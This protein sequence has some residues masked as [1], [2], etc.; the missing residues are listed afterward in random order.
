MTKKTK[1]GIYILIIVIVLLKEEVYQILFQA[2][3]KNQTFTSIC[4][5]KNDTLEEKYQELINAYG[6]ED[7][8]PYH[9]EPSKILYRDIYNLNNQ[10]TIYKGEK[11]GIVSKN[12]VINE[13]GLVGIVKETSK[14][15]SVVDLL[16]NENTNLSI[17]IGESYG[18]LKY[19]D[20][21][22]VV[23]GINNKSNIKVGDQVTTSDISLYPENI[24]IGTINKVENDNYEIEKKIKVTPEVDFEHLKY[25]SV[26]TD[27]RGVE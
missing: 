9:L 20:Q 5:I 11:N 24:L 6:Y 8:V 25:V 3:I 16:I 26:I 12:L 4:Q 21:E 27:I 23:E 1:I 15:S 18:I 7:A 17:K 13:K 22:L 2:N 14:N 10:V 19:K